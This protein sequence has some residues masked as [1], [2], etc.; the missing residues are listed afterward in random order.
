MHENKPTVL[1]CAPIYSWK[2][3]IYAKDQSYHVKYKKTWFYKYHWQCS[4]RFNFTIQLLAG[5]YSFWNWNVTTLFSSR[6]I[7][8]TPLCKLS[9][10]LA[11]TVNVKWAADYGEN[12]DN[13]CSLLVSKVTWH[14]FC[15]KRVGGWYLAGWETLQWAGACYENHGP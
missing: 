3:D 11:N 5:Q 10:I 9:P 14:T 7:N 8:I 13:K 12:C 15:R 6:P 2:S 4:G 1:S